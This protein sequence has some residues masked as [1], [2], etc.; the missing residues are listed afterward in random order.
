MIGQR[1]DGF[2]IILMKIT[3]HATVALKEQS[4]NKLNH[5]PLRKV[6]SRSLD[7]TN[8][9]WMGIVVSYFLSRLSKNNFTVVIIMRLLQHVKLF[10]FCKIIDISQNTS[11]FSLMLISLKRKNRRTRLISWA[12]KIIS[13]SNFV[14][15]NHT[16]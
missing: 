1:V 14:N 16:I 5:K 4:N 2:I 6:R 11:R 13:F 15:F 8:F 7:N 9:K 3:D 10:F 12:R